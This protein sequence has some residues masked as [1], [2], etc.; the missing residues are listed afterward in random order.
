MT[1]SLFKHNTIVWTFYANDLFLSR[2]LITVYPQNCSFGEPKQ[3]L[4]LA[5]Y[6]DPLPT[7]SAKLCKCPYC[8]RADFKSQTG[9]TQHQQRSDFCL[10]E[11]KKRLGTNF[12]EK[13]ASAY[14]ETSLV[15]FPKL[16]QRRPLL[17]NNMFESNREVVRVN[18]L[19]LREINQ[20]NDSSTNQQ[21]SLNNQNDYNSP[22]ESFYADNFDN[23]QTSDSETDMEDVNTVNERMIKSFHNYVYRHNNMAPFSLNMINAVKLMCRLRHTKA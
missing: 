3:P 20:A 5:D 7:M 11:S 4:A 9:L 15:Y 19:F 8:K 13:Q 16:T 10:N 18:G 12:G 6:F 22:S 17:S 1:T 21:A 23:D 14:L 2:R